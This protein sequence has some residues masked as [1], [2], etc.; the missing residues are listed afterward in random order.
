MRDA[1]G[2]DFPILL[3]VLAVEAHQY[4]ARIAETPAELE[5]I[6]TPLIAAGVDVLH[7]S[8]RR[9]YLP[10][11]PD[12]DPALSLSGWTRKITGIPVIAVGSVGL[13]T[14]S[15]GRQVR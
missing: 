4:D 1:V 2:P 5:A 7:P 6:L 11:F 13:A 9:H 12:S 10:A 8:T 15:P 3:P 14:E